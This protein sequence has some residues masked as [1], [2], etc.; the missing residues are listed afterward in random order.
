MNLFHHTVRDLDL[1]VDTL[2]HPTL[3]GIVAGLL[4]VLNSKKPLHTVWTSTNIKNNSGFYTVPK[5][6]C[7]AA[8]STALPEALFAAL[9]NFAQE[10]CLLDTKQKLGPSK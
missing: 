1:L 6:T 5:R 4:G 2:C 8:L 10:Q 7:C 9:I 3:Q